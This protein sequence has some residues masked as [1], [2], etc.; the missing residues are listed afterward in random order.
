MS[1][2]RGLAGTGLQALVKGVTE[3]GSAVSEYVAPLAE[4]VGRDA[5]GW[6]DDTM[7]LDDEEDDEPKQL[8]PSGKEYQVSLR[9][10]F[11]RMHI[12]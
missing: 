3:V 5:D 4:D 9:S 10:R 12:P 6:G 11:I 2:W 1:G 7:R 8:P